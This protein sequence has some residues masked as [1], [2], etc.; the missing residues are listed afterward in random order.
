MGPVFD[1]IF[2]QIRFRILDETHSK[3]VHYMNDFIIRKMQF[4]SQQQKGY[5]ENLSIK[6]LNPPKRVLQ[7]NIL[8]LGNDTHHLL[9]LFK[10]QHEDKK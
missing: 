10:E 4:L 8:K 2:R 5:T 7:L 3:E 9:F 6:V 1:R